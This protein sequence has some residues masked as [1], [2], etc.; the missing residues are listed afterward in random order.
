MYNIGIC[1]DGK[2][3]CTLIEDMVLQY[4]REK[5]IRA[6]IS[7]WYTGEG[8]RDY[9]GK[10]NHLDMVFL[11]IELFKMTGIEVADYIRNRL[12]DQG[13]QIIYI[14]GKDSYARQLFKTQPLVFW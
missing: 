3:V 14:S 10:E 2:N 13:M 11:D 1:D 9:L 5:D 7:V 4:V 12:D 6:D 8:L